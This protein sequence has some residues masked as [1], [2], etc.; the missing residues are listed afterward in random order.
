MWLSDSLCKV[1]WL[2]LVGIILTGCGGG[3]G[4]ASE[5]STSSNTSP[6]ASAGSTQNVTT[7]TLV[8]LNGSGSS[9]ANGDPLTY[10]WTLTS[11]PASSTATLTGATSA[12]PTFTAD[13]VGIYVASLVVND[14][15]VNST[16]A[17][18][19]ITANVSNAA[20][21][22]NAGPAQN[23][24][25]GTLVTL[26]G[27]TSSDANGD[28]LTYN[29]TLT[30][31]PASSTAT[32]TGATSAAPTF[33]ADLVGI[34]VASLVV[35]DGKVNST[36][37]T[38]TVT[39]TLISS[40]AHHLWGGAG[41]A[42]YL[43]CLNCGSFDAN[44]VCNAFGTY[45]SAFSSSSIWNNF[46]TYGSVFSSYSPW[47]AF[48]SSGPGIFSTDGLTFYGYFTVNTFQS[49][50][51]QINVY[52]SVLSYFISTQDLALTRTYACGV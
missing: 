26:N 39:A 43:G 46:G 10:S 36:A 18:V 1:I 28:P 2:L 17:T 45:G 11:K 25:T 35:N 4:G 15:K 27:S 29:W 22:A 9:D 3:G 13:L 47:N 6:V 16:A 24:T 14:G 48:S 37:S 7:G 8:T 34:Y 42:T 40:A 5:P 51:T 44:S 38:V 33:T 52:V 50:R 23:V 31:K 19:T 20:P 49:N 30:S 21:V 32:L 41:Y 12:V